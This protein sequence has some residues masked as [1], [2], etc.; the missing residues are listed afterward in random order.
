MRA[1]TVINEIKRGGD[2][3]LDS[4]GVGSSAVHP[5]WDYLVGAGRDRHDDPNDWPT[6]PQFATDK[7]KGFGQNLMDLVSKKMKCDPNLI[8]INHSILMSMQFD[9][10]VKR[11][12]HVI[13]GPMN[14]IDADLPNEVSVEGLSNVNAGCATL[15]VTINGTLHR[16]RADY[17]LIKGPKQI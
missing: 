14:R 6:L 7:W 10:A 5:A 3:P 17:Y 1:R 11:I 9:N 16:E 8:R 15:T 2:A 4:L 13:E 12:I